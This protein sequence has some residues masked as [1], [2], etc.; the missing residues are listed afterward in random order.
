MNQSLSGRWG[1]VM[2]PLQ[3]SLV[4]L[5]RIALE[6]WLRFLF[7]MDSKKAENHFQGE[8]TELKKTLFT[9]RQDRIYQRKNH[10]PKD[11]LNL[12]FGSTLAPFET[13]GH[14]I[15]YFLVIYNACLTSLSALVLFFI[16]K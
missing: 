15:P 6:N 10:Q 11:I 2:Y 16:I 8:P 4:S 5:Y 3:Y 9:L 13:T 1:S 12:I 7:D 14:H